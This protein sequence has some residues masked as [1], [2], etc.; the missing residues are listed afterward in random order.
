MVPARPELQLKMGIMTSICKVDMHW[1]NKDWSGGGAKS[2]KPN[3]VNVWLPALSWPRRSYVSFPFD[4]GT[5]YSPCSILRLIIYRWIL[6]NWNLFWTWQERSLFPK[7]LCCVCFKNVDSQRLWFANSD[8]SYFDILFLSLCVCRIICF[9]SN[10][11]VD[12]HEVVD[13][14]AFP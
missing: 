8:L 6:V 9:L 7:N 2:Q 13:S 4:L 10:I 12:I 11:S 5:R 14:K 3:S 1:S